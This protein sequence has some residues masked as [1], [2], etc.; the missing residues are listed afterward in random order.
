MSYFNPGTIQVTALSQLPC[1]SLKNQSL[2]LGRD[3]DAT[4]PLQAPTVSRYHATV[5][6][7]PGKGYILYDHST[8]GTF[9][10]GQRVIGSA[11]LPDRAKLQ[12]GPFTLMRRGDELRVVDCGDRIRLDAHSLVI[13]HK[14]K[15]R[16]DDISLTIEPG[17]LVALVGGSGAGKSTLLRTLLGIERVSQGIVYL[18]GDDLRQN[19]NVYRTQIGYVPQDDI[20]HQDLRVREVLAYAAELRLPPDTNIEEVVQKLTFPVKSVLQA[21]NLHRGRVIL[22]N[23]AT[24]LGYRWGFYFDVRGSHQDEQQLQQPN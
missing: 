5:E 6:P 22:T 15:R 13:Q 18:N 10:D 16:L 12:I 24:G 17:Q 7:A 19:F 21:A 3:P 4:L 9:I 1:I 14:G 23:L 8:N 11:V 20:I 2:L